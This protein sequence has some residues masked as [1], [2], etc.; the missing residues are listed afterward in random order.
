MTDLI[1]RSLLTALANMI[2]SRP[3]M[4]E[5]VWVIY[6]S[7]IPKLVRDI[8]AGLAGGSSVEIINAIHSETL[9]RLADGP[10]EVGA[11]DYHQGC[12]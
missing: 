3:E 5:K 2:G 12:A 1:E 4:P 8:R 6:D 10:R 9:A 11:E 7:D